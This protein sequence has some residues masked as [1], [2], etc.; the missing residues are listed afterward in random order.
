MSLGEINFVIRG[1]NEATPVCEAVEVSLTSVARA[2]S[3]VGSMGIHLTALAADFGIIDKETSKWVRTIMLVITTIS[4]FARMQ[5]Y[6]TLLTTGH[7]A[8]VAVNTATQ[9]ANASVLGLSGIAHKI[10]SGFL[11]IATAAQNAFNI[12]QAAA[13]ALTG[14]GIGVLVAAAAAV[15]IF[16]ANM[17]AATSAVKG[18]NEAA[19]ETPAK[20]HGITRAGEEA[21][22]R[23][24]VE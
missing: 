4:T 8:S 12:S 5:S 14:I 17:N 2:I 13:I 21:M 22:Y 15:A 23:H 16:A 3:T 11:A 1:V 7:T 19:S 9:T 18:Y 10:H 6:L 24:G 20:M